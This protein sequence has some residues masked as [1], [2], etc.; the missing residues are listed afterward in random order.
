MGKSP[1]YLLYRR[2]CRPQGQSGLD[3]GGKI[4]C[5]CGESNPDHSGRNPIL[6]KLSR[7][8]V[9]YENSIQLPFNYTAYKE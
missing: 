8:Q 2:L 9:G 4:S 1:R 3:G 6:V 7:F 5:V